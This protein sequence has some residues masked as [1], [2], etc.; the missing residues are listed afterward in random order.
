MHADFPHVLLRKRLSQSEWP[1]LSTWYHG[2]VRPVNKVRHYLQVAQRT[3]AL[4]AV[5]HQQMLGVKT[6]GNYLYEVQLELPQCN[7]LFVE[8]WA[9]NHLALTYSLLAALKNDPKKIAI[10]NA[11]ELI[12]ELAIERKQEGL[13]IHHKNTMFR[14]LALEIYAQQLTAIGIDAL[15][16]KNRVTE[17]G[18]YA[19]C[20]LNS[21]RI[22]SIKN[23]SASVVQREWDEAR[24]AS[25]HA[26]L[27][28]D[29]VA[30]AQP[31]WISQ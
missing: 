31:K 30:S 5:A 4:E 17:S 8:D 25:I 23:C 9:H 11:L 27:E 24:L 2:T 16:Y 13:S 15:A 10:D 29:R 3:D 12:N 14:Q 18:E 7:V 20:I 22:A 26:S 19:L 28:D 6:Y 1:T 21:K